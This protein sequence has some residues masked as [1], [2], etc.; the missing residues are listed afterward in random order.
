MVTLDHESASTNH[1]SPFRDI[2]PVTRARDESHST[3]DQTVM[4]RLSASSVSVAAE[5]FDIQSPK[6]PF[7][8]VICGM[9]STRG[10][11]QLTCTTKP[12][13]S[14]SGNCQALKHLSTVEVTAVTHCHA[15][16]KAAS[17]FSGSLTIQGEHQ[18]LQGPLMCQ[19]NLA[20]GRGKHI[21]AQSAAP[22]RW[23]P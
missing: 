8:A 7:R 9:V 12:H 17:R 13:H 16:A 1:S 22:R 21:P 23:C 14:L 18:I 5:T 2:V 15:S 19:T 6:R 4:A 3:K 10:C 11:T 20:W